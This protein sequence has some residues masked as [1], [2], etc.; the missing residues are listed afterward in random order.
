LAIRK[1]LVSELATNTMV[2]QRQGW[3]TRLFEQMRRLRGLRY[4][5]NTG[6]GPII[7]GEMGAL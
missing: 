2:G 4:G 3:I 5:F 6:G 7:A 1:H